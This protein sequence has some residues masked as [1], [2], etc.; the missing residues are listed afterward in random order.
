MSTSSTP[1]K[2]KETDLYGPVKAFLE[3]QG[4]EV[5]GEIGAVDVLALG[6]EGQ[7]GEPLIVELKTAFS[8][9][10]FHQGVAR[11]SV[12]D[13]VYVAVPYQ[14]G[15]RWRAG[16]KANVT[17]ARR[18]GLGIMTVRLEDGLVQVHCDPV[19]YAPRKNAKRK[20][21]LLKEFAKRS[22]DPSKGGATRAGLVT[23]YRQDAIKI[24]AHLAD[25]GASRGTDVR[26]ATGVARAT[27]MM[28]DN[29]Y[30]WFE[31]VTTGVYDL[32]DTGRAA[33]ES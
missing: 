18:I 30:G 2:I 29:H 5:K 32:S 1:A 33:I 27:T 12:S 6:G 3:G 7:S 19:P 15:K 21:A 17:L 28:R 22:G 24:A 16:L 13:L 25:H 10:L 4:Y 31:K 20:T 14:S 8:L 23:A 26:N 9:S 11:L